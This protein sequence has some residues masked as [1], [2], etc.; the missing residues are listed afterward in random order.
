MRKLAPILL[1]LALAL[2]AALAPAF[3]PPAPAPPPAAAPTATPPPLPPCLD[4][5]ELPA[6]VPL[7]GLRRPAAFIVMHHWG[8][9]PPSSITT[10]LSV[11]AGMKYDGPPYNAMFTAAGVAWPGRPESKASGATWGLN[12][13]SIAGCVAMDLTRQPA[14]D[15][16]VGAFGHWLIGALRRHP[17][18]KFIQHRD[19]GK[20]FGYGTNCA[21]EAT[22]RDRTARAVWLVACGYKVPEA[23]RRA[24][25]GL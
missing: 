12:D 2:G 10:M 13:R 6:I 18:A 25:A 21:G 17:G 8:A 1:G 24:R 15:A 9:P 19:A 16:A 11:F 23:R 7:A 3:V 14:T 22:Q 4:H 5:D 20:M